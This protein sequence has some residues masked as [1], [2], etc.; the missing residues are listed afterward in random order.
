[1][2]RFRR[3]GKNRVE[4]M[5]RIEGMERIEW[6]EWEGWRERKQKGKE[7]VTLLKLLLRNFSW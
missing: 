6:K 1:M 7:K 2:G 3:N 5:G 4:E